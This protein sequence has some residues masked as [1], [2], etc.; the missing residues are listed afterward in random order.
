[1]TLPADPPKA[2][3]DLDALRVLVVDDEPEIAELLSEL[4]EAAGYAVVTAA[5]GAQALR[6]LRA[7]PFDAIVSD[8][9]MPDLDGSALWREVAAIAPPLARRMLFV[10]GDTLGAG[11]RK[12]LAETGCPSLDKPFRRADLLQRMRELLNPVR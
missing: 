3:A 8:L 6:Q 5:S 1:M 12:V 10:T 4:L 9:H 7:S 2:A 11:A